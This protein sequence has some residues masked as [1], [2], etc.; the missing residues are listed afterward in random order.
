MPKK[1]RPSKNEIVCVR[2]SSP[3]MIRAA[4]RHCGGQPILYYYIRNF[5]N[6]YNPRKSLDQLSSLRDVYRMIM[7]LHNI[8]DPKDYN[9][10][11]FFSTST[12]YTQYR[13]RLHRTRGSS[14][15]FDIVEFLTC[16]CMKTTWAFSQKSCQNRP[17]ITNR[18][19]RFGYP[20]RFNY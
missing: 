4:C 7:N 3:F 12:T 13:P 6:W 8:G 1:Q 17:E 18:K 2:L 20:R 10:T 11:S 15:T 16:D 19:A 14:A 9:S 5:T